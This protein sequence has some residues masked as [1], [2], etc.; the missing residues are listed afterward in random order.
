MPLIAGRARR[1]CPKPDTFQAV[2]DARHTPG[3]YSKLG[4]VRQ[5]LM[6]TPQL[7]KLVAEFEKLKADFGRSTDSEERIEL[8]EKIGL[9]INELDRVIIEQM[10]KLPNRTN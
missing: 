5:S 10:A 9:V 2:Y 7:K 1:Y 4:A 3:P 6:A 8:L